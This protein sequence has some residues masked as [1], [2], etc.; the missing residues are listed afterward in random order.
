MTRIHGP[1]K[2]SS[3]LDMSPHYEWSRGPS[4]KKYAVH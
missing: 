2:S 3:R 4:I 1:F